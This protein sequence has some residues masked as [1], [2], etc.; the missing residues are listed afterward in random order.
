MNIKQ[1]IESTERRIGPDDYP[2]RLV[3]FI[4]IL[5]FK[6]AVLKGGSSDRIEAI[7]K[8]DAGLQHV[9]KCLGIEGGDWY[10]A[11]LFSDCICISADN[12]GSNLYYMLYELSFLQYY[13]ACEHILV[14][15]GLSFGPHFENERMIFSEGLIQAYELEQKANHPRI[16]VDGHVQSLIRDEPGKYGE[17]LRRFIKKSP[18]G[19]YFID[20]L[21]FF[22]E[23]VYDL[24]ISFGEVE[25][26]LE[27]H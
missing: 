9:L 2:N 6:A 25:E 16:L 24:K 4:D 26:M 13:L 5:G 20:Y 12:S 23:Q 14:R 3:A 7:R 21:N 8:L 10:S 22:W 17:N 18:D 15:G 1:Q 11:R 19:V 27:P